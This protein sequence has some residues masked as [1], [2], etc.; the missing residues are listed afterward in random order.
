VIRQLVKWSWAVG[1]AKESGSTASFISRGK[2]V[3]GLRHSLQPV[4]WYGFLFSP[5]LFVSFRDYS[6]AKWGG[7]NNYP[8]PCFCFCQASGSAERVSLSHHVT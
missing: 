6:F 7:L 1:P 2:S 4:P 3:E 5:L 8:A